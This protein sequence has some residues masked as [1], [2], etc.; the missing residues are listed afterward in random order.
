[1]SAYYATRRMAGSSMGS[2]AWAPNRNAVRHNP[3]I[4]LGPVSHTIT[5]LLIVACFGLIFVSQSAKVTSYDHAIADVNSQITDL[6]AQKDALAV[7]NAKITAGAA[8][9]DSNTVASTMTE[10]KSSGYANN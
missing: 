6:E 10:A 1:M 4:V 2:A 8:D 5:V 3:K 9:E 7:E